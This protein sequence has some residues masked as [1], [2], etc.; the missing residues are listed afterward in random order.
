[1]VVDYKH[2]SVLGYKTSGAAPIHLRPSSPKRCDN[3]FRVKFY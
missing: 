2:N 3:K 1:M